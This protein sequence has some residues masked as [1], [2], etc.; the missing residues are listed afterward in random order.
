MRD[1]CPTECRTALLREEPDEEDEAPKGEYCCK[2]KE[3]KEVRGAIM[4]VV[5]FVAWKRRTIR[6]P[7]QQ[8]HTSSL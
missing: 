8:K 2:K 7:T 6:A 1:G 5:S 4:D 3:E